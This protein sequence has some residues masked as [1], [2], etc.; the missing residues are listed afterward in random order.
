MEEDNV[1]KEFDYRKILGYKRK[2]SIKFSTFIERFLDN[3]EC[4]MQT[5]AG[6]ILDA[7]KHF[8]YEI[9][10]RSGEP[11]LRYKVFHDLFSNGIN[12]V[13]GQETCIKRIID[14]IDSV[15][16]EA[17]PKRGLV[18]VGP[19]AS[20]KTNVV[21]LISQA[22]EE[23]T[24]QEITKIYTFYWRLSN[25]DGRELE[26]RSSLIPNPLLLF[27]ITLQ[28]ENGEVIRP[29]EELMNHVKEVHGRPLQIP[30]Y[31]QY[32]TPDKRTLDIM[33]ALMQNPRNAGKH[34]YDLIEEYVRVE[35]IEFSN[36]QGR[37]ISNVD[38]MAQ[39]KTY[40]RPF[41]LASE[42]VSLLNEHLQG[43]FLCIKYLWL[44]SRPLLSRSN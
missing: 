21:D 3:P 12:A 42:D 15:D 39:L 4:T 9:V 40:V 27:P 29:R 30:T 25:E 43:K 24:K 28:L 33:Q 34:L 36:A 7:I 37:G 5:S 32:A 14:V 16:K 35:E 11:I 31:Y 20:G 38:D 19:P 2:E 18:L 41:T 26:L 17:G 6:L 10:V 23:Y 8:G 1:N 44:I 22:V 13:Y